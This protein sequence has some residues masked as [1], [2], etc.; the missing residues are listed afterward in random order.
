MHPHQQHTGKAWPGCWA[1]SKPLLICQGIY[2]GSRCQFLPCTTKYPL[3]TN[4]DEWRTWRWL[5]AVLNRKQ[6]HSCK[7]W[8][9]DKWHFILTITSQCR[10]AWVLV[11][12]FCRSGVRLSIFGLWHFLQRQRYLYLFGFYVWRYKT[13]SGQQPHS[14]SNIYLS[15]IMIH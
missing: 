9:K 6:D 2:A 7:M 15:P 12:V 8:G 10:L 1:V 13:F 14:H 11:S 5:S 3:Y 4:E